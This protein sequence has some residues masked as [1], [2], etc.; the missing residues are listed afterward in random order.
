MNQAHNYLKWTMLDAAVDSVFWMEG[1][2]VTMIQRTNRPVL[3]N[4]MVWICEF[5]SEK[6]STFLC[7]HS[8]QHLKGVIPACFC[9]SVVTACYQHAFFL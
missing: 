2:V 8:F 3:M 4:L 9:L 6:T 5:Q 7:A 1:E